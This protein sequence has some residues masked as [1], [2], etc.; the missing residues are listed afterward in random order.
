MG[1][2]KVEDC[3]GARNSACWLSQFVVYYVYVVLDTYGPTHTPR[4]T[5]T[6]TQTCTHAHSRHHTH[7]FTRLLI[8]SLGL[9][10]PCGN[11]TQI[12]LQ[13]E[14]AASSE[15]DTNAGGKCRRL[16]WRCLARPSAGCG[17]YWRGGRGD[18]GGVSV[19]NN[20]PFKTHAI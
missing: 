19:T 20:T 17:D 9:T 12:M 14:T 16:A 7:C 4:H 1:N 6:H 10:R 11:E 18:T 3:V 15:T 2:N 8:T 5:Q 13:E